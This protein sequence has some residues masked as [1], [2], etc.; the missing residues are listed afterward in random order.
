[1]PLTDQEIASIQAAEKAASKA[2][3]DSARTRL[4][5]LEQEAKALSQ[6]V[7][8]LKLQ[9][10]AAKQAGQATQFLE[11]QLNQTNGEIRRNN[12]EITEASNALRKHSGATK[13]DVD[14]L[15]L[16]RATLGQASRMAAEYI[17]TIDDTVVAYQE[18]KIETK[19]LEKSLSGLSGATI[20]SERQLQELKTALRLTR[21]EYVGFLKTYTKA[22]DIGIKISQVEA[23]G[24]KLVKVR[25]QI[26]GMKDLQA[27]LQ[28]NISSR[29]IEGISQGD[30]ESKARALRV[31]TREQRGAI[32]A[33]NQ[34][35]E[36]GASSSNRRAQME[37]WGDDIKAAFA[38]T[39]DK[40]TMGL[41][42]ALGPTSAM[43][44]AISGQYLQLKALYGLGVEQNLLLKT[45]ATNT[46]ASVGGGLSNVLG[47]GGKAGKGVART[48][49]GRFAARMG[50]MVAGRRGAAAGIRIAGKAAK[51]GTMAGKMAGPLAL[52]GLVADAGG[53]LIKGNSEKGTGQHVAGAGVSALGNIAGMAGTGAML[54]SFLGPIGTAVGALAGTVAGVVTS[55]EDLT[56]VWDY[57]KEKF[58]DL[59]ATGEELQRRQNDKAMKELEARVSLEALTQATAE[60]EEAFKT[61]AEEAKQGIKQERS[62]TADL[63]MSDVAKGGGDVS[64]LIQQ[65]QA[66]ILEQMRV[67]G[68]EREEERNRIQKSNTDLEKLAK[69][70]KEGNMG[71]LKAM[72]SSSPEAQKKF[73][74]L[75]KYQ[76]TVDEEGIPDHVRNLRKSEFEKKKQDLIKELQPELEA[77]FEQ[78]GIDSQKI[79]QNML[80]DVKA[81]NFDEV[82]DAIELRSKA[83]LRG[84]ELEKQAAEQRLNAYG[85][86]GDNSSALLQA[87]SKAVDFA[88]QEQKQ[89]DEKLSAIEGA[90]QP[91]K[92]ALEAELKRQNLSEEERATTQALL[93]AK[94]KQ[95]DLEKQTLLTDKQRAEIAE[96]SANNEAIKRL[97]SAYQEDSSFRMGQAGKGE[98]GARAELAATRGM[99]PTEIA[100]AF[101]E[102]ADAQKMMTDATRRR[103][104]ADLKEAEKLAETAIKSAR[105]RG[106]TVAEEAAKVELANTKSQLRQAQIKA[107]TDLLND[108][109]RVGK[110]RIERERAGIQS[111]QEILNTEKDLAEYLGSSYSKIFDLQ[112][113]MLDEQIN[114]HQLTRQEME[115]LVNILGEGAREL[116]EYKKLEAQYAKEAAEITKSSLGRQRDFL[117]KALGK[118]FGVGSGSKFNPLMNDRM[119]FGEHTVGPGGL[120][121]GGA[122]MTIAER[123][124]IL[125]EKGARR[126]E[127]NLGGGNLNPRFAQPEPAPIEM[128]PGAPQVAQ[129]VARNAPVQR[130]PSTTIAT[131][132]DI[133]GKI[134]VFVDLKNEMLD[135]RIDKRIT[136]RARRGNS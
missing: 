32:A 123:E 44:L 97:S 34:P 16:R 98:A 89:I 13:E 20:G 112:Q 51:I 10:E 59:V 99:S 7:E 96:Q 94:Q 103:T 60:M 95:Y 113:Q 19:A 72:A 101:Q 102:V 25:G 91:Q 6:V 117:D 124:R 42:G 48:R 129:P 22:A 49:T 64:G 50:G 116:P 54:G 115:N 61:V 56:E 31:A 3:A 4:P 80:E 38:D 73:E 58:L 84:L 30:S 119:I 46:A 110:E 33:L 120:R 126:P 57:G 28:G 133:S 11:Q 47:I 87:T 130:A 21:E 93:D 18:L 69:E 83:L 136:M 39:A 109:L 104:K 118:A 92:N 35:P 66:G 81:L 74:S 65:R 128:G 78:L 70:I 122:P 111:H 36:E 85:L 24:E 71:A 132:V 114:A 37:K 26:Q 53:S 9:I 76:K 55:Y 134:D 67:K 8:Q 12:K 77:R 107:E 43:A 100:S 131:E 86:V 82:L 23:L 1:M 2:A 5:L 14:T 17:K 62:R 135:A 108:Q 15:N 125:G 105:A 29:S 90:F 27:L 52:A 63:I 88:K 75:Q 121:V 106:D 68:G 40:F 127:V 41:S 79:V 45:I